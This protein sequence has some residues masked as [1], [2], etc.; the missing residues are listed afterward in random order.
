MLVIRR[1]CKEIDNEALNKFFE[2]MD[3][4]TSDSGFDVIYVNGDNTLPNLRR[5]EDYWKVALTE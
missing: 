3:F 1:N 5:D 2:R 4:C